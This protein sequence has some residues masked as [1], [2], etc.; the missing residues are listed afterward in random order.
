MALDAEEQELFDFAVAALPK[1]FTSEERNR[2]ELAGFAKIFG[3]ALAMV[4][5]WFGQTLISTAQGPLSGLPDWLNQHAIDHATR[6]QAAESDPALRER[7]HNTPDA[8]VR[9]ALLAAV[10]AILAADGI[11]AEAAMVELP[12]HGAHSGVYQSDTGVGGTFAKVG[13]VV[14]FT[15]A[16]SWARPPFWAAG[17]VPARTTRLVIAGAASSAN[18]GTHPVTGLEVDQ[19]LYTDAGG[20]AGIDVGVTWSIETLDVDGNV[21]DGWTR[22]YS[23]R[24]YRSARRRPLRIVI[25]LPYGSTAADEAS[26]REALRQK[27]AAGIAVRIERRLIP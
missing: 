3:S 6:R 24:G 20:V 15:P 4:R 7:L 1:W 23:Q 12:V 10:N 11:T 26:V 9:A 8:V 18:N 19:A 5:Y 16:T 25:I 2:E 22:A 13:S 21:R 14:K 27:K 17:L